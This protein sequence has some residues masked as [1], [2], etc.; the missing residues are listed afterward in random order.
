MRSSVRGRLLLEKYDP[1]FDRLSFYWIRFV[2]AQ[3]MIFVFEHVIN[4]LSHKMEFDNGTA[5]LRLSNMVHGRPE[6]PILFAGPRGFYAAPKSLI[7]AFR[8]Q[9]SMEMPKDILS[10]HLIPF[11]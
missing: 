4:S 1:A 3:A 5:W 7:G 8:K 10:D 6:H 2:L 9:T 11:H